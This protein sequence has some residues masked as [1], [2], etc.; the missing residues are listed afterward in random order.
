METIRRPAQSILIELNPLSLDTSHI[1]WYNPHVDN[2]SNGVNGH[3]NKNGLMEVKLRALELRE[4]GMSYVKIAKQ[5]QRS[6]RTAYKYVQSALDLVIKEPAEKVLKLEIKR[7]DRLLE[8]VWLKAEMGDPDSVR[9]AIKIM[10]RRAKYQG[11][12]APEKHV[13][14][15]FNRNVDDERF[16]ETIISD[17]ETL[18]LARQIEEAVN[19]GKAIPECASENG[20]GKEMDTSGSSEASPEKAS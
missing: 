3:T 14:A 18:G 12:D 6:S 5:I 4:S 13:V 15:N 2:G 8:A 7:L 10:E 20:D 17:P 9:T 1:S 11:L 16:I 19:K